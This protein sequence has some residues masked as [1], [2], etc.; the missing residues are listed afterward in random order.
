[1]QASR[2][3]VSIA[4]ALKGKKFPAS[5][6]VATDDLSQTSAKAL[7]PP[8]AYIWRANTRGA[9]CVVLH[10]HRGFSCSWSSCGGSSHRAML[11]CV[12]HVWK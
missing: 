5:I 9:W 12:R 8:G 2:G 10:P 3:K 4:A 7:L 11:A 6:P 1:M